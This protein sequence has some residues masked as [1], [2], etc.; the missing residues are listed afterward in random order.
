MIVCMFAGRQGYAS[1]KGKGK[2]KKGHTGLVCMCPITALSSSPTLLSTPPHSIL[3]SYSHTFL[4]ITF[5][6]K[7]GE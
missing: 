7:Q 4:T 5:P 1:G 6:D 3:K 2:K